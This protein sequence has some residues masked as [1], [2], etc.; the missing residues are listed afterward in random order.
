MEFD[1]KYLVIGYFLKTRCC[2]GLC[3]HGVLGCVCW[4]L[5][6]EC[7][8]DLKKSIVEK[9]KPD[10]TLQ[11]ARETS[12]FGIIPPLCRDPAVVVAFCGVAV[13]DISNTTTADY[14]H[15]S[16]KS[17]S[18]ACTLFQTSGSGSGSTFLGLSLSQDAQFRCLHCGQAASSDG[19]A[20]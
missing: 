20:E 10:K 14:C 6:N 1:R 15:L 5:V 13:V 19:G 18:F 8:V 11:F 3:S 16:F 12:I 17:S 9:R 2:A 7:D 4:G